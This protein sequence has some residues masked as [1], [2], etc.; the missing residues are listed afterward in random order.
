MKIVYHI[1]HKITMVFK[2]NPQN[3]F[4]AVLHSDFMLKLF[5]YYNVAAFFGH[6][7]G[8]NFNDTN[9]CLTHK[10]CLPAKAQLDQLSSGMVITLVR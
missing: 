6:G 7:V 2:E 5:Q 8:I 3:L 4:S 10:C 1:I 9:L